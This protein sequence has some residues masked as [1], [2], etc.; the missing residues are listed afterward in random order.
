MNTS[1]GD[2]QYTKF[3]KY[4]TAMEPTWQKPKNRIYTA[5]IFSFLAISL[6][7]WYAIKPTVQT[8]L[9]LRREIADK[10]AVNDQMEQK[11]A[12]L[13]NA[14]SEL[15]QV[16]PQLHVL[17]QALPPEPDAL[18]LVLQLRNIVGST[19]ASLSSLTVSSVPVRV[20]ATPTNLAKGPSTDFVI[21]SLILGGFDSLE[22]ILQNINNMR[23][24][25][26]IDSMI[27]NLADKESSLTPFSQKKIKLSIHVK[28]YY[29]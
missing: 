11:I 21:D 28:S 18:D 12:D 16:Q 25:V 5:V 26:T 7:G 23:R 6:F 29:K 24:I 10:T 4:Y 27:F 19:E 22:K 20:D 1:V 3:R 9:Y 2:N 13:I 8:I 15:D 17:A 14:R